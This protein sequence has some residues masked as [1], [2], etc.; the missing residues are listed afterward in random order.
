MIERR[1]RD[2]RLDSR[3]RRYC[4]NDIVAL[5]GMGNEEEEVTVCLQ[6][7]PAAGGAAGRGAE[8]QCLPLLPASSVHA[9]HPPT[10][11]P[12]QNNPR[13]W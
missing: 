6:V 11:P 1:V 7:R 3:L 9:T 12:T 8:A 4:Q 2:F 10:H 13:T 5:C